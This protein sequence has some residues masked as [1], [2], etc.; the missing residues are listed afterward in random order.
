M[1]V[2]VLS[3]CARVLCVTPEPK[4]ARASYFHAPYLDL[5][6]DPTR[7]LVDE[8]CNHDI[9]CMGRDGSL[10]CRNAPQDSMHDC[11]EEG[12]QMRLSITDDWVGKMCLIFETIADFIDL[13]EAW[14]GDCISLT[15]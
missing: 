2:H 13:L 5:A 11:M 6:A 9:I 15:D 8:S 1:W 3:I 7:D 14:S 10:L 12:M 4:S